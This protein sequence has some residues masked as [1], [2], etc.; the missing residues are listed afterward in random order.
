[1]FSL[2][3]LP[4]RPIQIRFAIYGITLTLTVTIGARVAIYSGYRDELIKCFL[5]GCVALGLFLLAA[6]EHRLEE[7]VLRGWQSQGA[8]D[9]QL[10]LRLMRRDSGWS[11][12]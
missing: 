11:G 4:P 8:S 3:S 12:E 9:G 5:A 10:R 7:M 1:M 6:E 2:P